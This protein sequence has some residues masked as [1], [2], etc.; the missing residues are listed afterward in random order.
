ML[1]LLEKEVPMAFFMDC[2]YELVKDYDRCFRSVHKDL[3]LSETDAKWL[4][5]YVRRA[6]VEDSIKRVSREHG[7]DFS[8]KKN[9]KGS[10]GGNCPHTE[11]EKGH[12]KFI[13]HAV[14]GPSKIIR[15]ARR[16]VSLANKSGLLFPPKDFPDQ[17]PNLGVVLHG[18]DFRKPEEIY[19][20][21]SRVGFVTLG[22]LSPE[23]TYLHQPI[24][25]IKYFNLELY[26]ETKEESNEDR[27]HPELRK[28]IK[29]K[30]NKQ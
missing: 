5:P 23:F 7:I 8:I 4:I 25:L 21:L 28:E 30:K 24:D 13:F 14:D 6:M 19:E 2:I 9:R 18:P 22:F 20:N 10:W 16:R 17:Y 29:T 3:N 26:P 12:F 15:R 1:S 27:V 11:I